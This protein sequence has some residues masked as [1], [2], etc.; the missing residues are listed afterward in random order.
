M[1]KK[2]SMTTRCPLVL[3]TRAGQPF[4]LPLA[5]V[6]RVVRAVAIT[7]LPE[8]PER[9]LGVINVQ[10]RLIAV[11][12]IRRP[13]CLPTPPLELSDRLIIA[14]TS[15]RPVALV[16]DSVEGV[17]LPSEHRM[18]VAETILPGLDSV[19]GVLKCDDGRLLLIHN[20]DALLGL[21]DIKRL[22]DA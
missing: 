3:F 4:A 13:W 15:R 22:D 2:D 9:V 10:G 6:E 19:E 21:E 1:R 12:D 7:P 5:A 11:I 18:V 14:H 17:E 16:A 8:A 20:L